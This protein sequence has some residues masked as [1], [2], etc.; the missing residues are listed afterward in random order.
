MDPDEIMGL[1]IYNKTLSQYNNYMQR[2]TM[3]RPQ[4]PAKPAAHAK[5][6]PSKPA[7]SAPTPA[8]KDQ[9]VGMLEKARAVMPAKPAAPAKAAPSKPAQR[10][11]PEVVGKKAPVSTKA[12]T[13]DDEDK[14]GLIFILVP[15]SKEQRVKEEKS[16]KTY[17]NTFAYNNAVGSDLWNHLQA[18]ADANGTVLPVAIREIMDCWV[19]QMG[20]PVVTVNTRTG[21]LSQKHFLLDPVQVVPIINR[22]LILDDTFNLARAKMIP[23]SL[24]INTTRFLWKERDYVPWKAALDNLDYFYLM[25]DQTAL[26]NSIQ[27]YLRKQVTPLFE[28]Y[29][30]IT[31][32]WTKV[33][34][35]HMDQALIVQKESSLYATQRRRPAPT[36]HL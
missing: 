23:I 22:A 17:L 18:A 31:M 30:N 26:Y 29:Q 13:K 32:N 24:A 21:R 1:C 33:P 35:G 16:L 7:Q 4:M 9:V 25:F 5:A 2:N 10:A 12:S 14:S 11:P 15:N 28:H 36:L 8:S 20:F 3:V 27:M 19:L 6:A 34:D